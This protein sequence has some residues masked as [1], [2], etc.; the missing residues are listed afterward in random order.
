MTPKYCSIVVLLNIIPQFENFI[1]FFL[2][3]ASD[4]WRLFAS[5]AANM[6]KYHNNVDVINRLT[7]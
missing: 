3:L 5:N 6:L 7:D 2:F 1:K 4:I